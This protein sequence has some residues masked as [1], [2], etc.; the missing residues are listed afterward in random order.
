VELC[1][2]LIGEEQT[3]AGCVPLCYTRNVGVYRSVS[4]TQLHCFVATDSASTARRIADDIRRCTAT[5]DA[6]RLQYFAPPE[7]LV[8]ILGKRNEC[9]EVGGSCSTRG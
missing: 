5:R 2:F 3:A 8:C 9:Y 7:K 1:V 6:V 4:C